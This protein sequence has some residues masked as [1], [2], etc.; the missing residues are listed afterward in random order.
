MSKDDNGRFS[1]FLR[2]MNDSG[3]ASSNRDAEVP[4]FVLGSILGRGSYGVV[5][6]AA[7]ESSK[8]IFAIK[9][10]GIA[11]DSFFLTRARS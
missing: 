8:E 4:G 6:I 9:V 3:A 1:C 5:R 10:S 7:R 11:E 2:K